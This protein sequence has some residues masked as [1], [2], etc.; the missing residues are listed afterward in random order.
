M[1]F[2]GVLNP[3]Q[4]VSAETRRNGSK[5]FSYGSLWGRGLDLTKNFTFSIILIKARI[6]FLSRENPDR[7]NITNDPNKNFD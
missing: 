5:H 3:F 6:T 1:S 2:E 4:A 7:R